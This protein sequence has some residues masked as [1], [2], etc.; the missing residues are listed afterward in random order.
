M[1]IAYN[2][3]TAVLSDVVTVEETEGLLEWLQTHPQGK[4]DL[5]S[6][7]HL[8]AANLQ[9]LMA[10]RPSVAAWPRDPGFAAWL[11]AALYDEREDH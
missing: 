8:H 9:V 7:V 11:K 2:E 1:T 5:S 6:C 3:L 4:L 10:A